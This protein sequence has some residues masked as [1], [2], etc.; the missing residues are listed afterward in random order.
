VPIAERQERA[1]NAHA[2][3]YGVAGAN[4]GTIHVPAE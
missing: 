1:G 4:L 3:I 2:E